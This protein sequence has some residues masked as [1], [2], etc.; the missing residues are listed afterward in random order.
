MGTLI[1]FESRSMVSLAGR[2]NFTILVNGK[3]TESL[4]TLLIEVSAT[5]GDAV[6]FPRVF[7]TRRDGDGYQRSCGLGD[8]LV[9]G[10]GG[11]ARYRSET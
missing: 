5:A 8:P 10:C 6:P 3:S 2:R 9:T 4:M 1:C 11:E 7:P